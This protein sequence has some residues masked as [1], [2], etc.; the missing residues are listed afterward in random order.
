MPLQPQQVLT[1]GDRQN[2]E[3]GQVVV[4]RLEGNL[5]FGRF[6]PGASYPEVERLFAEYIEAAN[7]QLLSVVGELDAAIDALGL[8]L[9]SP[10][11]AS[12]LPAIYD[13]QIGD[14]IIT[15][16]IR[17]QASDPQP[18][19]GAGVVPLPAPAVPPD[20]RKT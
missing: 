6:S 2:R 18:L 1:L 7:E 13:V 4:D 8:H 9:R 15:F 3:L 11:N 12:G 5:V 19:D 16:R 10:D 20:L 17:G 14:G